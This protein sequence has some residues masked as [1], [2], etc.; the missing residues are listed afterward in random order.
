VSVDFDGAEDG[1]D[2]S[3][4]TEARTLRSSR[5]V[6]LV[7]DVDMLGVG[8][9]LVVDDGGTGGAKGFSADPLGELIEGVIVEPPHVHAL[10]GARR[11]WLMAP[12]PAA[13]HPRWG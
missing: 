6:R 11:V 12:R 2:P 8:R 4:E 13:I 7:P 5:G 3:Q 10:G 9:N 1:R